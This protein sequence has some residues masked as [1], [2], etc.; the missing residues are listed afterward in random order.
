VGRG[1]LMIQP[2]SGLAKLRKTAIR[3]DQNEWLFVELRGIEPLTSCMPWNTG[4][5]VDVF[6]CT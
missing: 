1:E 4:M 3:A 5:Y 6:R 2:R